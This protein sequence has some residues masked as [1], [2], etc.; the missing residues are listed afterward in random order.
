MPKRLVLPTRKGLSSARKGSPSKI[1]CGFCARLPREED[2]IVPER[3]DAEGFFTNQF[4]Q[5]PFTDATSDDFGFAGGQT[6]AIRLLCR[7]GRMTLSSTSKQLEEALLMTKRGL[8][9]PHQGRL[10]MKVTSDPSVFF[11]KVNTEENEETSPEH[12]YATLTRYSEDGP[13]TI[14]EVKQ[15]LRRALNLPSEGELKLLRSPKG[16]YIGTQ[17]RSFWSLKDDSEWRVDDPSLERYTLVWLNPKS[18]GIVLLVLRR[19]HRRDSEDQGGL[20]SINENS[21]MRL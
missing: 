11:A 12:F 20:F 6:F 16:N 10:H 9:S 3:K 8:D 7:D 19:F 21:A 2:E 14:S 17:R 1:P 13:M 4:H 18:Q 5:G 15:K